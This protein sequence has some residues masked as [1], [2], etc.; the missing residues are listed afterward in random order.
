ML[1][2]TGQNFGWF[3][4][5][6]IYS[7]GYPQFA[8]TSAYDSAARALTLTVRQTQVDTATADSTGF[9]FA[10]PLA[11]RAPMAIRV[12][13]AAGDVVRRV[14]IDRREQTLRMDGL[15]GAPTMVAFDDDNAVLKTL[16]FDQPTP[17]LATLLARHPHLWQRAWAVQQLARR[18]RIRPPRRRSPP[19][20]GA[21]TT[22]HSG[23]GRRALAGFP[24]AVALPALEAAARDT[25]AQ[26]RESAVAALAAWAAARASHRRG[27]WRADSSDEVRAAALRRLARLGAP[28]ARAVILEALGTPSYRDAIQNAAIT[29]AVQ[30]RRAGAGRGARAGDREPVASRHGAGALVSRGDTAARG[31]LR[32][33]LDDERPWVREWALEAVEQQLDR[34]RRSTCCERPSRRSDEPRRDRGRA[35]DRAAGAASELIPTRREVMVEYPSGWTCELIIVKFELYLRDTLSRDES[36]AVAEHL[37]ACAECAQHL[38]LWSV[39]VQGRGRA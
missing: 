26:V 30:Q 19:R 2:A 25:S 24:A 39:A 10:V 32:S 31:L 35:G 23:A 27:A 34:A 36:L 20:Y 3:W 7:A 21:P 9:R 15:P 11:F 4:S 18:T 16:E 17:W 37:E 6:W 22:S 12:G 1:D 13:T 33:A 8:V 28:E 29:L 14:T 5:Q 38:V